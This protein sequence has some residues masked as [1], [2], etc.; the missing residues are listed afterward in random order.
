[1]LGA[2]HGLAG[3]YSHIHDQILSSPVVPTLT[4]TCSTLLRVPEQPNTD[5]PTS[6]D[7]S[8]ALASH[9]DDRTRPRKQG[10]GRPKCEHCGKLG[11]KIDKCYA[12]HE[13]EHCG[14]P[15]HKI[16]S[17][18]ALH[19]RSPRSTAAVQTNLSP[20]SSTGDP[21]SSISSDTP[22]MFYKF[23][24]WYKDQE[25]SSSTASIAHTGTSFV[26][27]TRSSSPGPWVF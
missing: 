18:Y 19:G 16:D 23:L 20:P 25:S 9:R 22:A 13:C 27:L 21:P 17:C 7:D 24:K 12:L 6:V 14:K 10:K 2:L 5:T 15:G 3:K 1:M 4:S 11:H 26:G 8:S